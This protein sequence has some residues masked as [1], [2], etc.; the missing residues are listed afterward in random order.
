[1]NPSLACELGFSFHDTPQ[2]PSANHPQ[3]ELSQTRDAVE[4]LRGMHSGSQ[5]H[6]SISAVQQN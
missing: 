3:S 1:M 2:T 4:Q 5:K 6:R